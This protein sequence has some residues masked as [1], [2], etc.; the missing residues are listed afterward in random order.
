MVEGFYSCSAMAEER[1]RGNTF[2]ILVFPPVFLFS[3][4]LSPY[5]IPSSPFCSGLGKEIRRKWLVRRMDVRVHKGDHQ[6][7]T[8]R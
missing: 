7:R 8:P 3:L 4:L 1:G 6:L 2:R 5:S